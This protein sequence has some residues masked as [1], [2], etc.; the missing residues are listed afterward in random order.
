MENLLAA[1]LGLIVGLPVGWF[2]TL[3]VA[4]TWETEQYTILLHVDWTTYLIAILTVLA[5]MALSQWPALRAL[6]RM[7]LAEAVKT[8]ES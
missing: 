5:A 7:D 6:S 1:M 4:R 8:T 2:Y 3:L